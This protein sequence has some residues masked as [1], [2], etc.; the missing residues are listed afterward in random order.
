MVP[1]QNAPD[2]DADDEVIARSASPAPATMPTRA[3][4]RTG[5]VE[6]VILPGTQPVSFYSCVCIAFPV[7]FCFVH[8]PRAKPDPLFRLA[9]RP[10]DRE[11][12]GC[13]TTPEGTSAHHRRSLGRPSARSEPVGRDQIG[14]DRK[15]PSLSLEI[16]EVG[17]GRCHSRPRWFR[18]GR[19]WANV[20]E[21]NR[22]PSVTS[23][24]RW[25]PMI[26][27][28]LSLPAS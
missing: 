25:R 26:N 6:P 16:D 23:G 28:P 1:S 24:Q 5:G 18:C 20:T 7:V 8:R 22:A 15:E 21:W 9:R 10:S 19:S 3:A 11:K 4:H 27:W 12:R 2:A 13:R 17:C 14:Q